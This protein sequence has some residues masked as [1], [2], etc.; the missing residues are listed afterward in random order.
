MNR[1]WWGVS[2]M[3]LIQAGL[4]QPGQALQF[5]RRES[6]RAHVTPHG[7]VLF[8]GVEYS[9]LSAA[10]RAV[11]NKAVNGWAAWR[12]KVGNSDWIKISDLRGEI[13]APTAT[14]R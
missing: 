3:D 5:N 7:T 12:V 6:T 9:S 8:Q 13:E 14:V 2:L 10:G 1:R 11:T 4:I